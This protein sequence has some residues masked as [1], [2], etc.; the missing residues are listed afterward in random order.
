MTHSLMTVVRRPLLRRA[1]L[2]PIQLAQRLRGTRVPDRDA[3]AA[4]TPPETVALHFAPSNREHMREQL[5][6][7]DLEQLSSEP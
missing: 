7:V 5:A 6:S 2:G 1:L 3:P 4:R